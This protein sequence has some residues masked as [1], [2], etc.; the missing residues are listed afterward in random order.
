MLIT[1]TDFTVLIISALLINGCNSKENYVGWAQYKGGDENIQYSSLTQVDTTNVT[2]LRVVWEYHTGDADTVNHSQI[3][4]NPIIVD[5]TLYGTSPKMKLFAVE[6]TTGKEKWTFN[7]FDSLNGN[8]LFFILNNCRG[9]TYWS[10]G[11]DD[12]RIYYTAGSYLYCIN[13][14]TGKPV[15][16]FADTGKLDLHDG[17]GENAKDLFV[18]ATS[19]GI[20]FND[21]IIMGTRVNESPQAA[22]GHIR[23]YD[24]RT[25]RPRWIFH[26]IPKPGEP[27]Y[28]SWD[29]P[30]AWQYTG[31]ANAWGGMGIDKERGIVFACTGSAN[32]DWYGGRRTGNN[33]FADCLLALDA[34]SGKLIWHFQD[35]HHDVWDRDLPAAPALVT[36]KKDGRAIDAVAL[37]TK[38][39][40][41]FLFERANGKPVY[42]IVEK[43][44]P[45]N[46][47]LVGEKLSPTQPYPVKPAPFM[48]Q[49]VTEKDI[50]PLLPDSSYQD[51]KRQLATYRSD[52]MF[53]PPSLQGTVEFPGLDGGAEWGGPSYDPKTGILYVNAN[54]MPWLIQ[55]TPIHNTPQAHENTGQVGE[56]LYRANC[57][58]CHGPDRKGSGNFPS[59]I[60]V[61]AKYTAGAFDTLIQTGRR[62]MPGFKQIPVMERSAIAAFVLNIDKAKTKPFID[63]IDKK[64]DPFR[65]PYTIVGY[66]KFLT[67]EGLPAIAPPWGTL[68]AINLNTGEYLWKTTLGTDADFPTSK[69]A[70]GTENYGAPVVTAGGLLF[71]AATKDGKLRAF[72]KRTGAVL[73]EAKLPSAAF[74][75]P[76]IYQLNGKQY[77]VIA[78][79]GGKLKT[80]SGDSYVAFSLPD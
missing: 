39:G 4:C 25:G 32:Y 69:E 28:E 55:A 40:F 6:A 26:T 74:A 27:G 56:R 43:P 52:H 8:P 19:P 75:T 1:K 53:N 64:N 57:M 30:N 45:V 58:S 48:R 61:Q 59:L 80:P 13:A 72:N 17:L 11:A 67:K 54:E 70:T 31:G 51:I 76:A 9:V 34:A 24:I 10:D 79:G 33:L 63:A 2:Q 46:S 78:C 42:D 21:M 73:W 66:N 36:V 12:K 22:P 23:A 38:S 77:L 49:L 41:L 3:Q 47:D 16:A 14:Q 62:M 15:T 44:V 5:G 29:D 20:V 50:N 68:N 35:I 60:N 7:P 37:T 71:I 18:T 65:L